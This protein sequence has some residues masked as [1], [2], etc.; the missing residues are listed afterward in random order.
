MITW[1]AERSLSEHSAA[2]TSIARA[3]AA[4]AAGASHVRVVTGLGSA[5]DSYA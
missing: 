1:A 5:H 2:R 3:G 4:D